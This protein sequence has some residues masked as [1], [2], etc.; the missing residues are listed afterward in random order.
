[1]DDTLLHP[2]RRVGGRDGRVPVIEWS[3]IAAKHM[4]I[5]L[6]TLV[7]S[8]PPPPDTVRVEAEEF[9]ERVVARSPALVAAEART[10]GAARGVDRARAFRN[11][12]FVV[13]GENFGSTAPV[14]GIHGWQG[15][16]GQAVLEA[17][18]P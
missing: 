3:P 6:L 14:T 2:P 13:T 7:G 11:P 16:E 1:E 4:L 5:L 9:L 10:E 8:H 18:L 12:Q 17:S 15:L